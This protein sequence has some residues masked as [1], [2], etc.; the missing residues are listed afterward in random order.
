MNRFR[1]MYRLM[2]LQEIH[3]LEMLLGRR[4]VA[5]PAS[6]RR[7][8]IIDGGTSPNGPPSLTIIGRLLLSSSRMN[9]IL[10][11]DAHFDVR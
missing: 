5:T 1:F 8:I 7:A 3:V 4:G 2:T 9:G 6:P 10:A 11:S